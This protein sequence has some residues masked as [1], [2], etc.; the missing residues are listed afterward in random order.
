MMLMYVLVKPKATVVYT[1]C[2]GRTEEWDKN[3]RE[4]F[5]GHEE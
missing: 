3:M 1:K 2:E 4:N 5:L